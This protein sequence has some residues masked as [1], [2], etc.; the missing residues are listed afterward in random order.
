MRGGVSGCSWT[1]LC[2]AVSVVACVFGLLMLLH[3]HWM[4]RSSCSL[5]ELWPSSRNTDWKMSEF[6]LIFCLSVQEMAACQ[7]GDSG[8][9]RKGLWLASTEIL[10]HMR[11]NNWSMLSLPHAK[12]MN[13]RRYG[14]CFPMPNY[15]LPMKNTYCCIKPARCSKCNFSTRWARTRV[16]KIDNSFNEINLRFLCLVATQLLSLLPFIDVNI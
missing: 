6:V 1:V 16:K 14:R 5:N 7:G 4:S 11:Q 10:W 12:K 13:C 15:Q 2:F 8:L 3:A 9:W